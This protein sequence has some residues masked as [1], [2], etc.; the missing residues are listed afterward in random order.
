MAPVF[1]PEGLASSTS[2]SYVFFKAV[3]NTSDGDYL[4]FNFVW[5]LT[6]ACNILY[7]FWWY[8][9]WPHLRYIFHNMIDQ[10]IIFKPSILFSLWVNGFQHSAG[11]IT[12]SPTWF[13]RWEKRW[14]IIPRNCVRIIWTPTGTCHVH[15]LTMM[16]D[17]IALTVEMQAI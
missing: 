6:N 13:E 3:L 15:S 4:L 5:F 11:Q 17:C 8:E 16:W 7:W 9:I 2:V 10:L 14:T 1:T 12:I